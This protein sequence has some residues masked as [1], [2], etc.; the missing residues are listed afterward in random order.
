MRARQAATGFFGVMLLAAFTCAPALVTRKAAAMFESRRAATSARAHGIVQEVAV[1]VPA[2][3]MTEA[4]PEAERSEDHRLAREERERDFEPEAEAPRTS[5]ATPKPAPAPPSSNAPS[6]AGA[7]G[8]ETVELKKAL[9][10]QMDTVPICRRPGGPE[11]PGI[12]EVTFTGDG[13][14]RVALSEPYASS[15]VG[16]CVARRFANAAQPFEGDP[17]TV[18]VRFEL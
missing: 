1:D 18:R 6:S 14:V 4:E 15:P 7:T 3:P 2:L 9:A 8:E 17:I 10:M 16:A 12:A 5:R 13:R 11:G